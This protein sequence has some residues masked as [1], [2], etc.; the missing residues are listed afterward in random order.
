[1]QLEV[2]LGRLV[3]QLIERYR[4]RGLAQL[5]HLVNQLKQGKLILV[6]NIK[7]S[8]NQLCRRLFY[9][10]GNLSRAPGDFLSSWVYSE[11]YVS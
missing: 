9:G 4:L 6:T 7:Y 2:G 11:Q 3:D 1:V 10:G 8:G 5:R